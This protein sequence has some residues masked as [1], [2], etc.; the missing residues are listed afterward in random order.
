MVQPTVEELVQ[1]GL[2]LPL[3]PAFVEKRLTQGENQRKIA[4]LSF[5][6]GTTGKP[7]VI[8]RVQ[9]IYPFGVASLDKSQLAHANM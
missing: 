7:K 3:P 6:S 5:S 1:E 4:F 8:P 2:S 9:I